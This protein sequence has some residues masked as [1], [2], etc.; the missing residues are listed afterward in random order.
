MQSTVR[1]RRWFAVG[2]GVLILAAVGVAMILNFHQ[3][4]KSADGKT[5]PP[6]HPASKTVPRRDHPRPYIAKLPRLGDLPA[7]PLPERPPQT[8][9]SAG[10]ED[11]IDTKTETLEN[12]T[13]QDDS[14]SMRKILAELRSPLPEIRTAALQATREF[15]SRDAIPYLRAIADD[16]VD[17][18]EQKNLADLIEYLEIPTLSESLDEPQDS[19]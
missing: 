10:N 3:A 16:T 6:Q 1:H 12:L 18:Q 15:G 9:G 19:P 2:G 14:E 13:W 4:P 7:L 17:F 8:P 5:P 11:W